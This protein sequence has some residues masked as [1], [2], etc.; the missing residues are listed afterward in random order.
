MPSVPEPAD[1]EAF[2][3]VLLRLALLDAEVQAV[4]QTVLEDLTSLEAGPA[5]QT[6]RDIGDALVDAFATLADSLEETHRLAG[7]RVRPR[8]ID[9]TVVRALDRVAR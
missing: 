6:L 9:R 7:G 3:P 2:R 8:E 1:P 4:T 5:Q